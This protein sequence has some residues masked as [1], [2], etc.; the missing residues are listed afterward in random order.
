MPVLQHDTHRRSR[1]DRFQDVHFG[2]RPGIGSELS[3]GGIEIFDA[4]GRQFAVQIAVHNGVLVKCLFGEFHVARSAAVHILHDDLSDFPIILDH[5]FVLL[6]LV[7]P[8]FLNR[9]RILVVGF[10]HA[11]PFAVYFQ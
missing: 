9:I 1:A 7:E 3:D 10:G 4:S 5:L 6:T 11:A 2:F 8:L